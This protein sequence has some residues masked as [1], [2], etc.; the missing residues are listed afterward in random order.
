MT[1]KERIESD[2]MI[3]W[4]LERPVDRNDP[5]AADTA[6]EITLPATFSD[7]AKAVWDYLEGAAYL[8]VYKGRLVVTD[9]SLELTAAGD[10]SRANP[11]GCPRWTV[12]TFEELEQELE[13]TYEDLKDEG[14]L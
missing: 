6:V 2:C 7:N 11:Y 10:G 13:K 14:W 8:Y 5:E 4:S 3:L 1:L 12:N 9:E